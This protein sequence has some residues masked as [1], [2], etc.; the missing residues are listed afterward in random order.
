MIMIK[1]KLSSLGDDAA[2]PFRRGLFRRLDLALPHFRSR[3]SRLIFLP[4]WKT[5]CLQQARIRSYL[6]LL[7]ESGEV[8]PCALNIECNSFYCH[9]YGLQR[10]GWIPFIVFHVGRVDLHVIL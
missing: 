4:G 7:N 9:V 1:P 5:Q 10:T 6:H 2:G 8:F 3:K